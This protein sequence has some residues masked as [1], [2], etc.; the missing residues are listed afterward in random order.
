MRYSHLC[1][2]GRTGCSAKALKARKIP[3]V[4][5]RSSRR[6]SR[7]VSY[8]CTTLRPFLKKPR[9]RFRPM[10]GKNSFPGAFL[11]LNLTDTYFTK[12]CIVKGNISGTAIPFLPEKFLLIGFHQ[13]V[14]TTGLLKATL[15]T[16]TTT[17]RTRA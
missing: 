1:W 8:R 15:N 6:R 11:S 17:A 10:T 14:D 5:T 4:C 9:L 13:L 12:K 16:T 7:T 2:A 3:A